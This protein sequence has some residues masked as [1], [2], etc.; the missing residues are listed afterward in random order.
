MII[1]RETAL[2]SF[3]CYTV[4]LKNQIYSFQGRMPFMRAMSMEQRWQDLA[5]LLSLRDSI[6]LVQ[7]ADFNRN[8][9]RHCGELITSGGQSLME[10]K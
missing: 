2:K 9:G 4:I 1:Y 8:F 5:S 3:T 7:L 10:F 6:L